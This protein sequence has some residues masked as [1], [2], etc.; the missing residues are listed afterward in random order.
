MRT[1]FPPEHHHRK[2]PLTVTMSF[3]EHVA[4]DGM[5]IYTVLIPA[6]DGRHHVAHEAFTEEEIARLRDPYALRAAV[7]A[8]LAAK[9]VAH[10][11]SEAS[12]S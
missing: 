1:K 9:I 7:R 6:L 12:C 8:K 11:H 10:I 2:G 4:P 5:V 3:H